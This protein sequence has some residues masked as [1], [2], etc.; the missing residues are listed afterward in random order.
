MIEAP[1]LQFLTALIS[2]SCNSAFDS[3]LASDFRH[4][5]RRTLI[6][7]HLSR[8]SYVSILILFRTSGIYD[9]FSVRK[10][11][12]LSGESRRTIGAIVESYFE[13]TT[14]NI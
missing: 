6:N 13:N 11:Q 1:N 7:E 12:K 10:F 4:R 9:T 2:G 3:A 5:A 8:P 14:P